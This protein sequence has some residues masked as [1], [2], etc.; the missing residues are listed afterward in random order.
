VEA[1]QLAVLFRFRG[2]K[3]HEERWFVDTE[4]WKQAF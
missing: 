3:I 1:S 4:Q 2:D